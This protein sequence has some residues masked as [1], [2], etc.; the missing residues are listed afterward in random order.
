M[1]GSQ[2]PDVRKVSLWDIFNQ[3]PNLVLWNKVR[4]LA[5]RGTVKEPEREPLKDGRVTAIRGLHELIYDRRDGQGVIAALTGA[6]HAELA[7]EVELM[8]KPYQ[9]VPAYY[10]EAPPDPNPLPA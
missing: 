6:G 7:H 4:H 9:Q 5:I 2:D 3:P 1:S 8:L 10:T